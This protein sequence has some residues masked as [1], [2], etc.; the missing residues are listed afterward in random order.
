M[1]PELAASYAVVMSRPSRRLE[2]RYKIRINM[3]DQLV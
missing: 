3:D 1:K 2:K